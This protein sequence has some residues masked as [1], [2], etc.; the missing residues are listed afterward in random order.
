MRSVRHAKAAAVTVLA[1]AA[2]HAVLSTGLSWARDQ[3]HGSP[4]SWAALPG[5]AGTVL[6]TWILMPL[7]L[8]GGMRLLGER[9]TAPLLLAC[10]VLWAA[11]T[12]LYVDDVDRPSGMMPV[13]ALVLFVVAGALAGGLGS[14]RGDDA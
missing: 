2:C 11:L 12:L 5:F 14:R 9:G 10:G 8:W 13:P 6:V 4:D 7:L 1:A 3:E